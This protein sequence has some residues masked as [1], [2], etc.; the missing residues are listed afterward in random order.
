MH[1]THLYNEAG[2]S[3]NAFQINTPTPQFESSNQPQSPRRNPL[4]LSL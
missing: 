1:P 2:S 4:S 3:S